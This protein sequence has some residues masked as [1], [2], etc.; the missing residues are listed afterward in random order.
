MRV[1]VTAFTATTKIEAANVS[2][3]AATAGGE[4]TSCQNALSPPSSDAA[5]TAAIGTSTIRLKYAVES[6][7]A[8]PPGRRALRPVRAGSRRAS[9]LPVSGHSQLVLDVGEDALLAVEETLA[10]VGPATDVCDGEEAG[11]RRVIELP[12][13]VL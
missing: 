5:T 2:L 12:E 13:D 11:R 8:R 7:S 6:P 1:P 9:G 10:D 3:S 4:L